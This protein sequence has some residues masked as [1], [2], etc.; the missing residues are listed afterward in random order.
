M[1]QKTHRVCS[2]KVSKYVGEMLKP[3]TLRV[4]KL[5]ER[6]P[7]LRNLMVDSFMRADDLTKIA[8]TARY[9]EKHGAAE[10]LDVVKLMYTWR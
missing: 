4:L 9:A 7:S 6:T 10:T 8:M 5:A 2:F 1:Q 3:V